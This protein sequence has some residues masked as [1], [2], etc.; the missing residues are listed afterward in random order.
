MYSGLDLN[1]GHAYNKVKP[2]SELKHLVR[3]QLILRLKLTKMF[4]L[5][6]RFKLF[7]KLTD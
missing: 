1:Q 5:R 3:F 2:R 6:L 7:L 4:Q